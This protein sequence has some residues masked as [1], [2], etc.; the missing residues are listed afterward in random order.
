MPDPTMRPPLEKSGIYVCG[1]YGSVPGIQWALLSGRQAAER[2]L[3]DLDT[4]Q[5]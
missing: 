3:K 4:Y 2:V 1:E 5:S